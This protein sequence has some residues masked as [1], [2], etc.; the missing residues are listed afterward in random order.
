V[1]PILTSIFGEY[2]GVE[3]GAASYYGSNP[4]CSDSAILSIGDFIVEYLRDFL[5]IFKN[6][7]TRVSGQ[8]PTG[9]CVLKKPQKSCDTVPLIDLLLFR[10]SLHYTL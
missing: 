8:E 10:Q 2:H 4:I 3:A 9:S 6:A 5:A 7:L 1:D